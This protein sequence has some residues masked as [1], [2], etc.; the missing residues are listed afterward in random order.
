M[1]LADFLAAVDATP[2][3]YAIV[4]VGAGSMSVVVD[5]EDL[6]T[7]MARRAIREGWAADSECGWEVNTDGF[8]SL[9]Y[10][11]QVQPWA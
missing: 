3:L 11:R 10:L 9:P 2:T 7:M 6:M 5:T 8:L 1:R 4:G